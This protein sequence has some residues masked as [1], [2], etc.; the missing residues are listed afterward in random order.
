M[1]SVGA[2]VRRMNIPAAALVSHCS[3]T[4]AIGFGLGHTSRRGVCLTPAICRSSMEMSVVRRACAAP[5][6]TTYYVTPRSPPRHIARH[7]P[8]VR[9]GSPTREGVRRVAS[10]AAHTQRKKKVNTLRISCMRLVRRSVCE[11]KKKVKRTSAK[12]KPM[13]NT[14]MRACP[15]PQ[16]ESVCV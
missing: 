11:C 5:G 10:T 12:Q 8:K 13:R 9:R 6:C 4:G 2:A 16:A 14:C 1:E 7:P 15:E 3:W